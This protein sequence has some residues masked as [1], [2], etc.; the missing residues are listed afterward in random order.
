M[1]ET[2]NQLQRI[3]DL[4]TRTGA[5]AKKQRGMR[6]EAEEW[7]TLVDILLGILQIERLQEDSRQTQLEQRFAPREHEHLGEVSLAWLDADLQSRIGSGTNA[8]ST[9][10]TLSDMD[11]KIVEIQKQTEQLQSMVEAHQ[12][13]L[14]RSAVSEIDRT[15]ALRDFQ[16]RFDGVAN[17]TTLVGTLNADVGSLRTNVDTVLEL[18]ES[19]RDATGAPIDVA[20]IGREVKEL[21]Q[22]RESF[23][24]IDGSPL[25]MKDLELR[26][27]DVSTVAG[28]GN[29]SLDSRF[30]DFS[31][32]LET[33]FNSRTDTAINQGLTTVRTENSALAETLRGEI[34]SGGTAATSAATA[35]ANRLI[36]A[37]N[38]RQNTA[39]DARFNTS[40]TEITSAALEGARGIVTQ[41]M[42]QVPEIARA[43]AQAAANEVGRGITNDLQGKFTAEITAQ[44][45]ATESRMDARIKPLETGLPALRSELPDLIGTN[46]NAAVT[47][48]QA[49]LAQQVNTQLIA[50]QQQIQSSLNAQV[51]STVNGA[52]SNLDTRITSAVN[53]QMPAI[54]T[55][56]N[57]TVASATRNL[58]EQVGAEVGRQIGA[59]NLDA[60]I[61]SAVQS[62]TRDLQTTLAGQLAAQ[63]A[64][65][66]T[67]I[68]K[69]ADTL[70]GETKALVD[71]SVTT[72]RNDI[73]RSVDTRLATPRNNQP[74]PV[75]IR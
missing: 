45:R 12:R 17:L 27:A 59:L 6:I 55:Q 44:V 13:A 63:E 47:T 52:L 32:Q 14:D 24:G 64:R 69:T 2:T 5:I 48:L 72:T 3:A 60:Q 4:V 56:V 58:N 74:G 41:Q 57:N 51:T 19:L 73:L 22:L 30:A 15:K 7:N 53:A 16:T 43:A 68:S 42:A 34:K 26:L 10:V 35:E 20:G 25:T 29:T 49:S 21:Q 37:N 65:L 39:L 18:R 9:R 11:R 71:V 40:R 46:V 28:V 66:T 75:I 54:T 31:A 67:L 33:R 70:R 62:S 38:D 23:K 36:A 8:V 61:K 50:T 1:A